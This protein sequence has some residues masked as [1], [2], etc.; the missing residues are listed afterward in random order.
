M[1]Q[2]RSSPQKLGGS[3]WESAASVDFPLWNTN[4]QTPKKIG[5]SQI[6]G[7]SGLIW[8]NHIKRHHERSQDQVAEKADLKKSSRPTRNMFVDSFFLYEPNNTYRVYAL[9]IWNLFVQK[10]LFPAF[11]FLSLISDYCTLLEQLFCNAHPSAFAL[12]CFRVCLL[13]N[14]MW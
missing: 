4:K 3:S 11:A 9:W 5:F 8:V 12:T 1:K 13:G 10:W 2:H 14:F 6:H 7:N